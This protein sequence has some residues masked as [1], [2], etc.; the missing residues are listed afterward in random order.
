MLLFYWLTFA[1]IAIISLLLFKSKRTI[2]AL[3][4]IVLFS[5]VSFF[6]LYYTPYE[7]EIYT[8]MDSIRI[9]FIMVFILCCGLK[10]SKP[11]F[12][13][14]YAAALLV[15]L[16]INILWLFVG[17]FYADN[18][19]LV[20]AAVELVIFGIGTIRTIKIKTRDRHATFNIGDFGSI[21]NCW[22]G[23]DSS[24]TAISEGARK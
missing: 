6:C 21:N 16:M 23:D 2:S 8:S 18:F 12:Y 11:I 17:D 10:S 19:Y 1:V 3:C 13:L 24:D 9:S 15:N 14:V 20:I 5:Y 7:N 22:S 4:G